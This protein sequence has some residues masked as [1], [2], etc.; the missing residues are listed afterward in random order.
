METFELTAT[1]SVSAEKL[2]R[3]WLD[4]VHHA[5]MSYGGEAAF[6]AVPGGD[7]SSG[8]GYITGRFV[9]LVPGR[10]LVFTWR[11]TDFAE[12]Q[13][14]SQVELDFADTPGGCTLRLVHSGLPDDQIDEYRSGWQDYYL[15]PMTRYFG[16]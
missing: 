14:D 7:H 3:A 11:T 4:P 13:P 12:G 10:R 15:E 9:E 8:D 1:F 2:Y 6:D 5:A 16:G